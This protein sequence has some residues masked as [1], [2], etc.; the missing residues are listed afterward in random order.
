MKISH[1]NTKDE[2]TS[3]DEQC[4]TSLNNKPISIIPAK[5]AKF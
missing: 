3:S 4:K 2:A 5:N 1:R